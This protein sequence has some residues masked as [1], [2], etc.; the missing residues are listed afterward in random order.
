M[1]DRRANAV[2]R[3]SR[4]LHAA[5]MLSV[6][7]YGVVLWQLSK[8]APHAHQSAA[9]VATQYGILAACGIAGAVI[10]FLGTAQLRRAR[11]GG[12]PHTFLARLQTPLI[13]RLAGA[14][15]IAVGGFTGTFLSQGTNYIPYAVGAAI[16]LGCMAVFFP[17]ASGFQL[18]EPGSAR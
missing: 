15:A 12:D 1:L 13:L 11:A 10:M 3:T 6:L 16:A 2:L 7:L 9:P 18:G 4:T 8:T 17:R 14:E 5:M